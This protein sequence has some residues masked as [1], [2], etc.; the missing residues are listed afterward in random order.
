[1]KNSRASE[2][3]RHSETALTRD[4]DLTRLSRHL[5]T[6]GEEEKGRIAR[7]LHDGLGSSLT[8]VTMDLSWVK[9]RLA[10]Q[11]LLAGRLARAMEVLAATV[12]MKRRL[13]HELRPTVLD[14]LGLNAA[15]ESHV[16]EFSKTNT[17][18]INTELPDELPALEAAAPIAL[19]R[20]YQQALTDAAR[21]PGVTSITVA[22]RREHTSLVL[23]ISGDGIGID[24]K[25]IPSS[26]GMVGMR[27]RAA[28]IGAA[29]S[30]EHGAAGRGS[31]VKVIL[32]CAET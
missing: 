8:A 11:P 24:P 28:A 25:E 15:I 13:I 17:V 29:L 9:Q 16:A 27:E 7:A 20:I 6:V 2:A 21:Q 26:I 32:P 10:D 12:D 22:L 1:M 5:L 31:V 3:V 19:F 30:I 14:N 4:D 18:S 23:E